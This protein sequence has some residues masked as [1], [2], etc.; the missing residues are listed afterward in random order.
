MIGAAGTRLYMGEQATLNGPVVLD[1]DGVADRYGIGR[2]KATELVCAAGFPNTVVPGMHRYPLAALEQWEIA[3]ALIGTVAEPRPIAP[4][5][6]SPPGA[7][8]PGRRAG[9]KAA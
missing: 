6:V 3:T 1:L 9:S 8:R 5:V 7:G 4:M 2:T